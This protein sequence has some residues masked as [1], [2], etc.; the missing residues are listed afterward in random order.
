MLRHGPPYFDFS[1]VS[2]VDY[3]GAV[4]IKQ[5]NNQTP[6]MNA[7]TQ[8]QENNPPIYYGILVRFA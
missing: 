3:S 1:S 7:L 2:T 8:V 6:L 5:S 4:P